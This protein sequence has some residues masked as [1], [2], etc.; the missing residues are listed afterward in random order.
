MGTTRFTSEFCV[1]DDV[2]TTST[3]TISPII[4][5]FITP[6][7]IIT[8]IQFVTIG[9]TFTIPVTIVKAT[10]IFIIGD[11]LNARR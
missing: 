6:A 7:T 1:I 2:C 4:T 8:T 3:T 11:S 10:V 9:F 5:V